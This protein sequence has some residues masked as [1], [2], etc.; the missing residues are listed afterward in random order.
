[1]ATKNQGNYSKEL[2]AYLANE[3]NEQEH[4][5]QEQ[6]REELRENRRKRELQRKKKRRQMMLS[7]LFLLLFAGTAA[8]F[9]LYW[10]NLAYG[11]C[12]VEAGGTVTPSDFLKKPDEAAVFTKKSAVIDTKVPGEYPVEIKT[13]MFTVSSK[14]IVQDTVAPVL[15]VCN[16][17]MAYGET[18]GIE[19]FVTRMEDITATSIAYVHE[20]DF[21]KSGKQMVN[22]TATDLGGNV[23]TKKA[24][25]WLTPVIPTVHVELGSKMP[26]ASELVVDGVVAEYVKAEA[27]CNTIGK[28][29]VVVRA[30]EE[31]YEVILIVEDTIGPTLTVQDMMDYAVLTK[32]VEDFVVSS[33]DISGVASIVFQEEP[34]FNYIGEQ[35]VT[36][37]A[38]DHCGNQTKQ[39]AKLVQVAD[40]DAPVFTAGEDFQI[41]LGDTVAYKSKVSVTDN[42]ESGLNLSVD[43][44]AVDLKAE[45][46]Y[47]VVYTATDAE[48]NTATKTLMLTVKEDRADEQELYKIIDGVFKSIF[49]DGMTNRER[50]QAIYDY[51][52][53]TVS[54][55]SHSDKGDEVKAALE[56]L[57]TGRGDCYVYFSLS[58]IMLTRAGFPNMDIER[59]RVGDSMHFWN[60]VDIGDGHGWYHFDATPRVGRP[61]I[62]LWDDA[63]IWEYSDTHNGSHNYDK[64]LY[65]EIK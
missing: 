17:A 11:V 26:E 40:E 49:K 51:I 62:F 18:C 12:R 33:E 27:D 2:E 36:I 46:V 19:A 23:T 53:R 13:G 61:Y 44:S 3:A 5:K 56:G 30:D 64:S 28:Y 52:R 58:K 54:Y 22:I 32:K 15:E 6:R 35:I 65:P 25:L 7:L 41:W 21:T 9:F 37:V 60:L 34:D 55:V 4:R 38:T 45:G 63:T 29:P 16:V 48:G 57:N 14:L 10:N 42:C 31:E 1:M 47:P 59:I 20:P 24:Q 8:G 50:C 39:Q 43:A